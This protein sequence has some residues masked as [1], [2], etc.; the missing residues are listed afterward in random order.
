[1]NED[2]EK[3]PDWIRWSIPFLLWRM[4]TT[5]P[6]VYLTFDDGPTPG[7]TDRI[8][9]ILAEHKAKATFFMLG[10]MVQA[11]PALAR[12]VLEEGHSIGNHGYAHLSGWQSGVRDYLK[13]ITAGRKSIEACIGQRVRL[14]RPPYGQLGLV[15]GTLLWWSYRIAMFDIIGQDYRPEKSAN[16]VREIIERHVSNGSIVL[17]H[18]SELSAP[19]TL[20]SLRPLLKTLCDRKLACRAL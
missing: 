17:M 11:N 1:M 15:Q 10:S 3:I 18:D 2:F 16:Q 13:D 6:A 8:L 5:V 20:E 7:V 4:P 19:R 9:D 14:F 12:R